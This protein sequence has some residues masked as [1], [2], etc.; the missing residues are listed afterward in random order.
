MTEDFDDDPE[1]V[2]CSST[3]YASASDAS[4]L[5]MGEYFTMLSY[6]LLPFQSLN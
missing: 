6:K 2:P 4:Y 3:C 5:G 1:V